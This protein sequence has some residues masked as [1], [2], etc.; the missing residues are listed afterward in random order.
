MSKTKQPKNELIE[1]MK[2]RIIDASK[3]YNISKEGVYVSLG[4]SFECGNFTIEVS[5]TPIESERLKAVHQ[6][7][8]FINYRDINNYNLDKVSVYLYLNKEDGKK[9]ELDFEASKEEI[10]EFSIYAINYAIE[11]FNKKTQRDNEERK[12]LD[13]ERAE[14]NRKLLEL[15]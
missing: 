14:E 9:K 5:T 8:Y 11:R 2:I 4:F 6:S 15:V 12:R 3:I 13:E 10:K 7:Y 1:R